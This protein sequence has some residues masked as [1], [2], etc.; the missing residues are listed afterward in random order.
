MKFFEGQSALT[1]FRQQQIL[2]S[3]QS[4]VPQITTFTAKT[5]YFAEVDDTISAASLQQLATLLPGSQLTSFQ[6]EADSFFIVPRFGTISPWSSKATDIAKICGLDDL[7]RI[8]HGVRYQIKGLSHCDLS[9]ILAQ[10]QDPMTESVAMSAKDLALLFQPESPQLLTMIDVLKEGEP[11]LERANQQL[12]LSLSKVEVDYLVSVFQELKRNPT[13]AEL[14]MFAQVNSEHC[15]HKI[16]NAH[17]HIDGEPKEHSLFAMIRNTYKQNPDHVLVAYDDNAAVLKGSMA[18]RFYVD[19]LTNQYHQR[20]EFIDIVFKVETHNHPT[21]ISPFPGAATGSGGEIRDEAATGRGART[22]MGLV[23]FS[24]SHLKIPAF[25]QSWEIDIGK[26]GHMASALDIMLQAPIGA[27]SFNNEFGRPNLCG[28]FRTFEMMVP[29]DYGDTYRGYHKPIMIAGGVGTTSRDVIMKKTLPV[30]AKLIVLGGPAMAIGLGGGAASSKTS[31]DASQDLDFASVQRSN[32]EM[33]RRCQEVIDRCWVLGDTNPILS[34]HDVGAGGL[35]NALPELVEA[36]DLGAT[37][38]LR[39]IPNAAPGM[40]PMEIWCNE[41]Q[42]RYVLSITIDQLALF[43]NIANRERC[44]FAIVG[45]VI[46]KADLRLEDQYFDN[47]AVDLPMSVLFKDL[48]PLACSADHVAELRQP[49]STESLDMA[50]S[51]RQVLQFPCVASK[52]FLITIG[53]RSITGL[54]ARDQMVGP[55]QVPV[56]DVAV[57]CSDYTG[58]T[59]EAL[60][61]GERTPIAVLHHAASARMAVGEAVTNIAA[62]NIG[63]IAHI[64]LS[65]NWMASADFIGDAAGLYDA[66]QSIGMELCPELGISIPVGK[67]SLSMRTEWQQDGEQRAVT[68]PLSLIISAAAKVKDV[69][70]TLTPQLITNQ[71]DTTLLLLDLG[72]GACSMGASVLAQTQKLLGQCP[73]D[74]DNP[75]A[76]KSFF[77][78][79]QALN[80]KGMILAYHDRSD[81]GLL[82]TICEMMFA[83]HVGVDLCLDGLHKEPMRA[84]FN[85]ELGAVIQIR[86]QDLSQVEQLLAV[87]ELLSCSHKIARLN[88]DDQLN[89]TANDQVLYTAPRIQLQKLWSETSYR[90]Q[91][92]RDHSECADQEYARIDDQQDPGLTPLIK[93]DV[94]EDIS[95]PYLNTA[96]RPRVAILREQGVNGQMEMAAAFDRVGFA[97]VDVHM[98]EILSGQV[99][100]DDFVGIAA[101]G[102]FS[103]GDVL[104]AGRGWAQSILQHSRVRDAFSQFFSRTD[105]FTLGVCNG[106]QMLS[107]LSAI[108]PGAAHWPE[109]HR[110]QSE[111]FEARLS[112]VSVT[113]SPSIFLNGMAGSVLPVVVAHGE[114]RVVFPSDSIAN[115]QVALQYVDNQCRTTEHYPEN[116]NGS[117]QGITGLT[118]TDG[119]VTIIMP[120]PERVF[121]TVQLSWAPDDWSEDSPWL[122]FF[123]NARVFVS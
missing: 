111:Q 7:K 54:V 34:I 85:E 27:A 71:G 58:Y 91:A 92:L 103:Y 14:M 61:M 119:R 5:W 114:G 49:F 89:I 42:E 88:N 64:A 35:S 51:I 75:A 33:Q 3:L 29:M 80:D 73:P 90:M 87:H 36:C 72:F 8:E 18:Q 45:E 20:E 113:D 60:A 93:F 69:R 25:N 48:P 116:P 74:V 68:S 84:L 83:A 22:K 96:V 76:L 16:F 50:E 38:Q 47:M 59:G 94:T 115:A 46:E 30:G 109:F 15:R 63:D 10:L 12:G 65:A 117:R 6:G 1:Q 17:W 112:L 102:G 118:T 28:Y 24:V 52:S 37:I 70:R 123:A 100:L 39:D 44:P 40:T 4:V 32:P 21:A 62:A 56:S 67:D 26:P 43:T 41:S 77:G 107:Q 31:S 82:A 105:T 19:S 66:V 110:N 106:C 9:A 79:I 97:S 86:D 23:G 81:G 95:A 122:R 57:T 120:H 98:S 78:L 55:W 121:R 99:K 108:I 11:A 101:C 13:D 104:G 2:A 53:D